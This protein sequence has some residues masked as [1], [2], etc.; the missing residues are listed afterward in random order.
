MD[1]KFFNIFFATIIF[2]CAFFVPEISQAYLKGDIY[3]FSW[4]D[5]YHN[6]SACNRRTL[7]CYDDEPGYNV[8]CKE[9]IPSERCAMGVGNGSDGGGTVVGCDYQY[10]EECGYYEVA[11][12]T[13]DLLVNNSNG[14]VT[15]SAGESATLSWNATSPSPTRYHLACEAFGAWSGKKD[16]SGSEVVKPSQTSEY[17]IICKNDGGS[18]TDAVTVIVVGD[19]QGTVTPTPPTTTSTPIPTIVPARGDLSVK[20]RLNG[21]EVSTPVAVEYQFLGPQTLQGSSAPH[22]FNNIDA[23]SANSYVGKYISGGPANSKFLSFSQ[24]PVHVVPGKATTIYMD[25]TDGAGLCNITVQAIKTSCDGSNQY[26]WTGSLS[27]GLL[28]PAILNGLSVNQTFETIPAGR[29]YL[30]SLMGGPGTYNGVTP[31]NP[32]ACPSGGNVTLTMK[33]RDCG[34]TNYKCNYATGRCESCA[35]Y[36]DECKY[37]NASECNMQ[38]AGCTEAHAPVSNIF[39]WASLDSDT[40]TGVNDANPDTPPVIL[41]N[42]S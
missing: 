38:C 40:C 35:L 27:Y 30:T 14:P 24:S 9:K 20:V 3:C 2:A 15:I 36:S 22:T 42:K 7:I 29:Y 4:N 34:E 12:P 23:N 25:F 5:C 26:P 13:V 21:Q 1:K 28:G 37:N 31:G 8:Y 17:G 39:C 16:T 32:V 41:Y 10:I 33:F 11:A 6:D 18:A 19:G